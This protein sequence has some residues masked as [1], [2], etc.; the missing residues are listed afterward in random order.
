MKIQR[1]FP[2]PSGHALVLNEMAGYLFEELSR[3]NTFTL[4]TEAVELRDAFLQDLKQRGA[5]PDFNTSLEGL[6]G[7][8]AEQYSLLLEWLTAFCDRS[9]DPGRPASIPETAL[10][11]LAGSADEFGLV[12][13][14]TGIEIKALRGEHPLIEGK[15]YRSDYPTFMRKLQQYEREKVPRFQK[16]HRL[17]REKVDA[18]RQELRLETFQPR[19]MSAFVR[20]KLIDQV[21]LPLI[22]D[23]L[24]KQLGTAGEHT[25]TDRMGLLLLLSPP[26]YGKTT[27]MEYIANR[28]GLIFMKINGPTIGHRV[29]A[30]DPADAPNQAARKELEK[31]NL[32]LEMGDNVMI[33]VDDIQ[34]CHPEFL[35]K[36][37]SLCDAQRRIE[38]V[39]KGVAK[40]Y[41]FR[42]RRVAVVMAGNPYTESGE[43]FQV[44]DMLANRADIYNLGDIIGGQGEVF[45]LSYLE[46]ALTSNPVLSRLANKSM[47]DVYTLIRQAAQPGAG[48]MDLKADHSPGALNEY[49]S[50]LK[51]LL[52]IR[53]V[54]LRVNR[55][56]IHS[57]AIAEKD[58]T[59]PPFRLQGS[60]R[61]MNKLAEKVIPIMNDA[62]LETLILSHYEGE[63]QTL[64]SGAEANRLK[65]HE[66]MGILTEAERQ[67]WDAI[68]QSFAS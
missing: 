40:S 52:R 61:N 22:G 55:Q 2:D 5:L 42:S 35:Q 66:I 36:F 43:R 16:F 20:N 47:A 29:H 34:H 19:V 51:K 59:E 8:P 24:A 50:V 7:L 26:G 27:L 39:W 1:F 54:V 25:R 67:R 64:T 58:R 57:A 4:G 28:L 9:E 12:E 62:E 53:E 68:R 32:A 33:Y 14:T 65:L 46:N 41:D 31:L 13:A 18:Y 23:N 37:I 48:T 44:P 56:Y 45:E 3:G 21:Y 38:G 60:Y 15:D 63:L 30:L 6:A 17:K 49:L 10:L 11:L